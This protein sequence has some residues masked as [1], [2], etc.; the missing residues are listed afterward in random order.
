MMPRKTEVR[1]M[2][3]TMLAASAYFGPKS[4]STT[5]PGITCKDREGR[6]PDGGD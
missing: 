3:P 4:T 2:I 5:T 1:A 6:E